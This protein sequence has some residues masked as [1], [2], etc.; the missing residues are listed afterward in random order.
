MHLGDPR[1]H[2]SAGLWLLI[3]MIYFCK[4][5]VILL[6]P[7]ELSQPVPKGTFFKISRFC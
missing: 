4:K 5:A 7:K 6:P 2:L 3:E 1:E